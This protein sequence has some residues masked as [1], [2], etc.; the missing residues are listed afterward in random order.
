MNRSCDHWEVREAK[1]S[2][3]QVSLSLGR[4]RVHQHYRWLEAAVTRTDTFVRGTVT[5]LSRCTACEREIFYVIFASILDV[6][7]S[8]SILLNALWKF[9]LDFES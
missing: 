4:Y 7:F 8:L 1:R 2:F 6:P 9:V 5:D 3:E